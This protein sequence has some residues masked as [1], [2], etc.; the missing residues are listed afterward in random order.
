MGD[1]SRGV[2]AFLLLISLATAS[3]TSLHSKSTIRLINP[4]LRELCIISSAQVRIS[5]RERCKQFRCI[6]FA[7][8]WIHFTIILFHLCAMLFENWCDSCDWI[9]HLITTITT[10]S[11]TSTSFISTHSF[12]YRFKATPLLQTFPCSLFP[13]PSFFRWL[14]PCVFEDM[15]IYF[16]VFKIYRINYE[17]T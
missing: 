7:R 9:F 8:P 11:S 6:S 3:S 10:I 15:I 16:K 1:F 5:T 4:Y 14:Q 2:T 13:F 12:S 17:R